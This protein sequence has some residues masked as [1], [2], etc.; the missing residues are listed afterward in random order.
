MQHEYNDKF[1][2]Q[3]CEDNKKYIFLVHVAIQGQQYRRGLTA[4]FKPLP[5]INVGGLAQKMHEEFLYTQIKSIMTTFIFL[6][7]IVNNF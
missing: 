7:W 2:I 5:E 1:T 6:V 4:P 3:K